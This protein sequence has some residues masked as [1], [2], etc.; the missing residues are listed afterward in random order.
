[1][2]RIWRASDLEGF[3]RI[4]RCFGGIRED[5]VGFRGL[6]RASEGI[7]GLQRALEASKGLRELQRALGR[8]RSGWSS[9]RKP[10]P[11]ITT[12]YILFISTKT[13]ASKGFR[14]LWRLQ[15]AL[16]GSRELQRASEG[17][18]GLRGL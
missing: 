7:R 12:E 8:R 11:L 4:I 6:Y 3:G 5:L 13:R 18:R 10:P 15:R 14:G 16:E 2:K 1:M 17:F 9:W